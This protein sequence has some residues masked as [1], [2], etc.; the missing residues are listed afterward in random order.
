LIQKYS[1][2]HFDEEST[3]VQSPLFVWW[4]EMCTSS[5]WPYY[6]LGPKT[7][8]PNQGLIDPH[9]PLTSL[10]TDT[11][12]NSYIWNCSCIPHFTTFILSSVT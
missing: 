7:P 1:S 2:L 11:T 3:E 4:W 12:K 8:K 9:D 10:W 6:V 5:V